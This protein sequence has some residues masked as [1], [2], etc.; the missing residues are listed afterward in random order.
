MANCAILG[1]NTTRD[2]QTC[3]STWLRL[4]QLQV[5]EPV[6]SLMV[7]RPNCT[8][9]HAIKFLTGGRLCLIESTLLQP[10]NQSAKL[11]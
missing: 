1:D 5:S 3:N 11:K 8:V 7:D 9:S 2:R 10:L 6:R 4:V